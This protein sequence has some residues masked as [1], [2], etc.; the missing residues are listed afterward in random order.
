MKKREKPPS[1]GLQLLRAIYTVERK[2]TRCVSSQGKSQRKRVANS[3][4]WQDFPK[5]K[6][7]FERCRAHRAATSRALSRER[8]RAAAWC[9]A[10]ARRRVFPGHGGPSASRGGLLAYPARR[11]DRG[12]PHVDV[13]RPAAHRRGI[14]CVAVRVAAA[15]HV[16]SRLVR[17]QLAAPARRSG[18]S[19]NGEARGRGCHGSSASA[20]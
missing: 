20:L 1:A 18:R 17:E 8:V 11:L 4:T 15:S 16:A 3:L 19:S 12:A 5:R 7:S 10:R 9:D 13:L 2:R 14:L 6:P